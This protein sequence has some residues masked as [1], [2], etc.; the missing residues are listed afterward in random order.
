MAEIKKLWAVVVGYGTKG[1]IEGTLEADEFKLRTYAQ[2]G[3]QGKEE[4]IK[5]HPINNAKFGGHNGGDYMIM[6]DLVRYLNGD[7]S[8]VSITSIADSVNGHL[9]VFAAEQSGRTH[10]IIDIRKDL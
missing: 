6:H 3:F 1:E 4:T 2:S 9:C 10:D 7:T 8:S 5:V